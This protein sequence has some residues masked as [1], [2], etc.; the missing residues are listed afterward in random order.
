MTVGRCRCFFDELLLLFALGVGVIK[1]GR[2]L[3]SKVAH[4]F[5][6]L[7]ALMSHDLN[8]LGLH[9]RTWSDVVAIDWS[10]VVAIGRM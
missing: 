4:D 3:L 2:H 5:Q 10:D 1:S 6:I 7:F 8:V 9:G